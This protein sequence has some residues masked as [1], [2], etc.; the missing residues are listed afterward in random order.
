MKRKILILLL[1]LCMLLALCVTASAAGMK[2]VGTYADLLAAF[3]DSS[4]TKIQ[5][6]ADLNV[7][8]EKLSLS[9]RTLTLDLNGHILNGSGF[10]GNVISVNYD[11]TNQKPAT[12][13]IKDS[14]PTASHTDSSLPN[15]GVICGGTGSYRDPSYGGGIFVGYHSKLIMEGGSIANCTADQGGGVYVGFAFF[16]MRGSSQIY[17]CT[18]RE[19]GGVYV[20]EQSVFQMYDN[21]SIRSCNARAANYAY[22]GGVYV[23][24]FGKFEMSGNS[25]IDHCSAIADANLAYGGGVCLKEAS[26]A[27]FAMSGGT[28]SNCTATGQNHVHGGGVYITGS[29]EFQMTGGVIADS[30]KGTGSDG[31]IEGAFLECNMKADGGKIDCAFLFRDHLLSTSQ[32]AGT[33][34]TGNVV[35]SGTISG[36]TF[37]GTVKNYGI[38]KGGTFAQ[39]SDVT[40][41]EGEIS[42]GT[43]NGACSGARTITFHANGGA[44][45]PEKQVR[46]RA[47]A[48]KPDPDPVKGGLHFGGWYS[49]SEMTQLYDFSQTVYRE[50]LN[51]YAEWVGDIL[52]VEFFPNG[53][54][55]AG[56]SE[57]MTMV[58][59]VTYKSTISE[60]TSELTKEGSTFGGWYT[61][62]EC[63]KP[64][65]FGTPVVR[66]LKLYAKWTASLYTVTFDT[67][68]GS[69]VASQENI[70]HNTH[71]DEPEDPIKDGAVFDGWYYNGKHWN[72]RHNP[73]TGNMTLEARWLGGA[74]TIPVT[75]VSLDAKKLSLEKDEITILTAEVTPANA[76]NTRVSWE[77]TDPSV[78]EVDRN[79]NVTAKI[80]GMALIVVRT[81]DGNRIATCAVTV[82]DDDTPTP[83][84]EPGHTHSYSESWSRN[85]THHW[86]VCTGC[87]EKSDFN[88]HDYGDWTVLEE[89]TSTKTGERER[90]CSTC[91]Y[92]ERQTIPATGGGTVIPVPPV[93]PVTP[94]T[95]ATPT[96]PKTEDNG[97]T[98]EPATDNSGFTD[99]EEKDWFADDVRYVSEKGLMNGTGRAE[100]APNEAVTRGMVVTILARMEG[101]NT[102]GSPWYAAGRKWAM[103]N[104]ISDGTN[105]EAPVTREQLAAM[106]FRY[107]VFKGMSAV[108]LADH[109]SQFRDRGQISGWAVP[110]ANW[111]VGGGILNGRS[112]GILDPQGTATRAELAAMLRR[113]ADKMN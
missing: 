14:N 29:S 11:N 94:V 98:Q 101:V 28:I 105:M 108:T 38:I 112:G 87:S 111:A 39:T 19:G 15:G 37:T 104:S 100:F 41:V 42:G 106:L 99:V 22:G 30:C 25:V 62:V 89:A 18:A 88:T 81:A 74:Q 4:V 49:D 65:T 86:H 97:G 12:L 61:D 92:T 58:K 20:E 2:Q 78:A 76:D 77:S 107:A 70:E 34:F 96:P 51:L 52:T 110:A 17:N 63:T 50:D 27:V 83:T 16:E 59:Q 56:L 55:F 93:T 31:Q 10:N 85:T 44:P 24:S 103:E 21:S 79:G 35:N 33:T 48:T 32:S 95:P 46:Y 66:N 40:N 57:D 72:F 36:G 84:P 109:L 26:E 9:G 60:P 8:G 53:G 23:S 69:E 73:V 43:F 47:P 75:G 3:Q 64:Y 91:G 113:F 5:L 54:A 1:C 45:E 13:I 90:T 82:T 102:S 68:G 80:A 7:T 71:A 67:K 6:T